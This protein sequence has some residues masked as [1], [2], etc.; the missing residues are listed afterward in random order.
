MTDKKTEA[1]KLALEALENSRSLEPV[2]V[3]WVKGKRHT[4]I[5][6]IREALEDHTEQHLEMV[7]KKQEPVAVYVGETWCGSVVRLYEDLPLETHLYTS[8][9]A[10]KPLT[11]LEEELQE[12]C[13]VI[14]RLVWNNDQQA[15]KDA[16]AF[17]AKH[18]MKEKNT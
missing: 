10:S 5:T 17:I 1:L 8:P 4:A 18:G 14:K 12:A 7:A 6:A 3:Q 16:G 11:A 15:H 9:P 2:D 13:K